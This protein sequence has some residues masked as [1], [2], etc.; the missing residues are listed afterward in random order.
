MTTQ[1]T[2]T[3]NTNG[4]NNKNNR[5]HESDPSSPRISPESSILTMLHSGGGSGGET[6]T[7]ISPS[8]SSSISPN[9]NLNTNSILGEETNTT[10]NNEAA[11]S[12]L[13]DSFLLDPKSQRFAVVSTTDG[14]EYNEVPTYPLRPT[15]REHNSLN[16]LRMATRPVSFEGNPDDSFRASSVPIYQTATFSQPSASEYG[17]YDYTRSGN[18]TRTAL[19]CQIGALENAHA[20]F[21]FV[22]GM[23]A[24]NVIVR[25]VQTGQTMMLGEDIYGGMHRLCRRVIPS[26]G[27]KV[28]S[29]ETWSLQKVQEALDDDPNIILVHMETPSNP[30]MRV[31]DIRALSNLLAKQPRKIWLSVDSTMM[32]PIL[33]QPINHGAD[34]VVHSMTKFIGGHSDAMGGCVCVANEELAKRIAFY[35]NAEG[36]GLSPFDSWLFLRGIKTLALRVITQ[37]A[38]AHQIALFLGRHKLPTNVFYAGL[39]PSDNEMIANTQ[40]AI[41]FK[42]HGGQAEGGGSVISFTT[43]NVTISRFIVDNLRLFRLTVSFGSVNS[44][45]EMPATLSHAS[46]PAHERTLPDDLIRLSIGIE[47]VNDLIEDLQQA[48]ENALKGTVVPKEMKYFIPVV[49]PNSSTAPIVKR[50]PSIMH[51]DR[52][53][54]K[55]PPEILIVRSDSAISNNSNGENN[56]SLIGT[57]ATPP[58]AGA[59][60]DSILYQE[61]LSSTTVLV[62][63]LGGILFSGTIAAIVMGVIMMRKR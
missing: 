12:L 52:I 40:R 50:Q 29:V 61:K 34:I 24:L 38:N 27:I 9:M 25:L 56:N 14:D 26:Q 37:Q 44:L 10:T 2:T 17:P 28:T 1:P 18:P 36:T 60:N 46:I 6:Q 57:T 35:Q 23:A 11:A 3:P 55:P 49:K 21:A 45:V 47:D 62:G 54:A 15:Y 48:F 5:H 8:L 30:M 41:D 58:A 43:G 4:N 13:M 16:R 39:K 51:H 42:I 22:S 59:A 31:T 20:A 7:H 53:V 19:E 33:Q 63:F 32:T